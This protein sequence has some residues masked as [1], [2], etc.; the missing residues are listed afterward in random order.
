MTQEQSDN[1]RLQELG[2][3]LL[4]VDRILVQE[5][6]KRRDLTLLVEQE[7]TKTGAG[8]FH[9]QRELERLAAARAYAEELG[10]DPNYVNSV[11]YLTIREACMMQLK[12]REKREKRARGE[13]VEPDNFVTAENYAE[14]KANL[15]A[16][17]THIASTYDKTYREPATDLYLAYE[18]R[19]LENV[20]HEMPRESRGTFVDLGCGT[21]NIALRAAHLF[22]K[23]V[24][25][26]L[27]LE[28]LEQARKKKNAKHWN[29]DVEFHEQDVENGIPL[30]NESVSF[31][32]MS[33]GTGSD[34]RH[35]DFVIA[36]AMRVLEANGR[37]LF[38]FYNRSALLYQWQ[39]VPWQVGI[40]ARVNSEASDCLEVSA[41]GRIFQVFGKPYT[42]DEIRTYF[43]GAGN[44][45]VSTYPTV[46]SVLPSEAFLHQPQDQLARLKDTVAA[47]DR[48]LSF[49]HHG[50]YVVA[51]GSKKA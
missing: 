22:R 12:E 6:A 40:S 21:G 13:H 44:L 14:Q 11:M 28:M 23:V 46:S 30:P 7:K 17:T 50:A 35:L 20:I 29:A 51:T 32:A 3:R 39:Y 42:I 49:G 34:V 8:I 9:E 2:G 36:E 43:A 37:F 26:D 27:S 5:L 4:L 18:D 15:R 10:L 25:Y 47:I 41:N 45:A 24:G 31:V 38:S 48:Q 33:L 16:L 19:A 1:T